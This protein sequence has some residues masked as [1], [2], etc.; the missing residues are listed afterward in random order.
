MNLTLDAISKTSLV[1]LAYSGAG[2]PSAVGR[3]EGATS[4]SHSAPAATVTQSGSHVV[5]YYADKA[6]AAHTWTL[7]STL[8]PRATTIGTGS[9]LLG[10]SVGDQGGVPAGTAPA[11]TATSTVSSSK[12]IMWTVVLPPA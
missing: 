3:A 10:V 4:A 1:L 11:L 9:G 8:T 7:P 6:N 12:A 5:R 2:S